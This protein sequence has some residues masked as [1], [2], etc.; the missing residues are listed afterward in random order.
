MTK[1]NSFVDFK[2]AADHLMEEHADRISATKEQIQTIEAEC[3]KL[4]QEMDAAIAEGKYNEYNRIAQDLRRNDFTLHYYQESLAKLEAG[5]EMSEE[6][7]RAFAAPWLEQMQKN[8]AIALKK[9]EKRIDEIIKICAQEGL[10]IDMT[11]ELL[12]NLDLALAH[13]GIY[14][15]KFKNGTALFNN[16]AYRPA[17]HLGELG[18][19]L[20]D[21]AVVKALHDAI[22]ALDDSEKEKES[23]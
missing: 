6:R 1:Y 2:A 10:E 14:Y 4:R 20:R 3:V 22:K 17:L 5:E 8:T 13:K 15:T 19:F 21:M 11:N 12:G 23:A 18:A 16:P 7:L 9:V